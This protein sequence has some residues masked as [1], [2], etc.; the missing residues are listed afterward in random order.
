MAKARRSASPT[1]PF[2]RYELGNAT[3]RSTE[4]SAV[5]SAWGVDW[6]KN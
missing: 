2:T 3:L 4:K 6:M 1:N 5:T